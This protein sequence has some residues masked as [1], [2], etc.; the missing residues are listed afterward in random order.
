MCALKISVP[1][2]QKYRIMTYTD[3]GK[4]QPSIIRS[5]VL[6]HQFHLSFARNVRVYANVG[7]ENLSPLACNFT[8]NVSH[9]PLYFK[10]FVIFL[11]TTILS[12][13]SEWLLLCLYL[14]ISGT[15]FVKL[16]MFCLRLKRANVLKK[17]LA[18]LFFIRLNRAKGN[19]SMVKNVF[20]SSQF[21]LTR[22][23]F[24]M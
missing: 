22:K 11:G 6:S 8:R 18:W 15:M 2:F 20:V 13:S 4:F 9:L 17:I 16:E 14:L 23:I 1:N 24:L 21:P 19:I 12:D 3:L 5:H 10:D 7:T